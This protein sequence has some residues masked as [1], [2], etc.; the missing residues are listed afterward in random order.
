VIHHI[1]IEVRPQDVESSVGFWRAAGFERVEPPPSLAEF[2]WMER[3]GTQVHLM[4]TAE[5]SVPP[6]GHIA[7]VAPDLEA[8]VERLAAAGFEV[9]WRK[10]H[11][12]S[13]RVKTT[14]PGGHV[15]E[16]MEFPPNSEDR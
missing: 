6:R 5:P 2:T 15:V 11:W 7:V 8:A 9:E 13:P 1:A 12:G 4:P 14:A 3:G 16:L 10:E